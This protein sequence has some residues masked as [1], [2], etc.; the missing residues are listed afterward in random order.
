MDSGMDVTMEGKAAEAMV[1]ETAEETGKKA[2]KT[3]LV[4]T[5][6]SCER[7]L[8]AYKHD[9][10]ILKTLYWDLQ[11]ELDKVDAMRKKSIFYFALKREHAM[12]KHRI[13]YENKHGRARKLKINI[14]HGESC[15]DW[16]CDGGDNAVDCNDRDEID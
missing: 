2:E 14:K 4:R 6:S 13:E 8:E 7:E 1:E 11:V 5:L 9:L 12:K 16:D 3:V 10:E 15:D